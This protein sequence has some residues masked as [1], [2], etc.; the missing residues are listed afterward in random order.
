MDPEKMGYSKHEIAKAHKN[1]DEQYTTKANRQFITLHD[2]ARFPADSKPTP[3]ISRLPGLIDSSI[4]K[5]AWRARL[6]AMRRSATIC[7]CHHI[8][9]R[10]IPC[11]TTAV[12]HGF[13]EIGRVRAHD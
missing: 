8:S 10:L 12:G 2:N 4:V 1:C 7:E 11:V 3:A 13:N 9:M 5:G 6:S